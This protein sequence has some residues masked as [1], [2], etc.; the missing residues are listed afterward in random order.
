[1]RNRSAT[2]RA[3]ACPLTGS[4]DQKEQVVLSRCCWEPAVVAGSGLPMT[5]KRPRWPSVRSPGLGE[6]HAFH[7]ANSITFFTT[8]ERRGPPA[9]SHASNRPVKVNDNGDTVPSATAIRRAFRR[10]DQS[11]AT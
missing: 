8:P 5:V 9:S 11:E 7:A 10:H 6:D 3:K 4:F 1:M 2:W